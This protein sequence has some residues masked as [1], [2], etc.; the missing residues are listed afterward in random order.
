MR[1]ILL[2]SLILIINATS[3]AFIGDVNR[4][5]VVNIADLL[6]V[7]NRLGITGSSV[8]RADIDGD[9]VVNIAD[10]LIVRNRLGL[11]GPEMTQQL[12]SNT[13][14]QIYYSLVYEGQVLGVGVSGYIVMEE[15]E[16]LVDE[17]RLWEYT[18]WTAR[19]L[20]LEDPVFPTFVDRSYQRI[21]HNFELNSPYVYYSDA[22]PGLE[23][24]LRRLFK[25]RAKIV[26]R[27]A[28]I[29]IDRQYIFE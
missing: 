23:S 14:D 12:I 13:L 6:L 26:Y 24:D 16:R 17:V 19:Y 29:E 10:L 27:N 28:L 4:D 9:G 8:G 22:Y 21:A 3:Y 7:R 5:W 18:V 1:C 20:G 15:Q 2:I 25:V 11:E